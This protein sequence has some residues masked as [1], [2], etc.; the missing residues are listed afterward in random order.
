MSSNEGVRTD[1]K[2]GSCNGEKRVRKDSLDPK[3]EGPYLVLDVETPASR[4][5][6]RTRTDGYMLVGVRSRIPAEVS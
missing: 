4:F 2:K 3:S 6:E 1:V 5:R